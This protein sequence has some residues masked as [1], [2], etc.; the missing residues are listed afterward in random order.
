MSWTKMLILGVWL[1]CIAHEAGLGLYCE[2][3]EFQS[4]L[5]E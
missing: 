4:F 5:M 1:P 3:R 2:A